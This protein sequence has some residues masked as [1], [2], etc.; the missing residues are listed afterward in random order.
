M[1]PFSIQAK[2]D[3]Q[4][5]LRRGKAGQTMCPAQME[6]RN[7]RWEES[8]LKE[9]LLYYRQFCWV[10]QCGLYFGVLCVFFH[11]A[12]F[13][14]SSSTA[15]SALGGQEGTFH[16]PQ[17]N[18]HFR[19]T[20]NPGKPCNLCPHPLPAAFSPPPHPPPSNPTSYSPWAKEAAVN[21][22]TV[23]RK[24]VKAAV[25]APLFQAS[26]RILMNLFLLPRRDQ[27]THA[28]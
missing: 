28:T 18:L 21:G 22:I 6:K 24:Q 23:P 7:P 5:F 11:L 19:H 13:V 8:S 9:L 25:F 2:W 14:S 17:P 16:S 20:E 3:T 12:I 10:F 4:G 15:V 26:S 27:Q 1:N